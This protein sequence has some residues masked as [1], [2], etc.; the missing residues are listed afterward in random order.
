MPKF[1]ITEDSVAGQRCFIVYAGDKPFM[2][3]WEEGLNYDTLRRHLGSNVELADLQD[4]GAIHDTVKA[5]GGSRDQVRD[6]IETWLK[7]RG[8]L[9]PRK[10]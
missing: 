7:E 4:I 9:S 2:T 3:L 6:A 1:H 8:W 5:L 10:P